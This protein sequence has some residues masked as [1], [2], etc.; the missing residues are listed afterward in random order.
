MKKMICIPLI[1]ALLFSFTGCSISRNAQSAVPSEATY[2]KPTPEPVPT[3]EPTPLPT[4]EPTP[5][6]T[7]APTPAP[8]YTPVPKPVPTPSP[9]VSGPQVIITKNPSSESLSVGG[10][11]WFIAHADN[12]VKLTWQLISPDGSVYSLQE[13]MN[14]NPGLLLESLEGDT[15]AVSNVP[16]SLNGWGVQA[17]FDGI[18]NSAVTTP[19]YIFVGDFVNAYSSVINTYMNAYQAGNTR[20]TAADLGLSE[21]IVGCNSAGYALKDLDKNGIPELILAAKDY[22]YDV[23]PVF[24]VYTL[25]NN[26]PVRLCCSWGRVRFYLRSDNTLLFEGSGGAA[27]STI[28]LYKVNGAGLEFIEGYST[29]NDSDS[30]GMTIYHTTVS[31]GIIAGYPDFLLGADY[32]QY[33]YTIPS[34]NLQNMYEEF[35]SSVWL[36]QLTTIY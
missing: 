5:V 15:I 1:L 14:L 17:R 36:P 28:E 10:H 6:P 19:A 26:Q 34:E 21:F 27:F 23:Q 8:V 13:A 22:G 20:Q 11:T 7:T 29:C 12:A 4:A 16:L 9:A 2:I 30:S 35:E 3:P 25:S 31:T 24:A 32:N 33:D 18:G